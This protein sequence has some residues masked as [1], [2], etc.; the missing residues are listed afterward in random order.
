MGLKDFLRRIRIIRTPTTVTT[1][2]SPT[3]ITGGAETGGII[4]GGATDIVTPSRPTSRTT[5]RGGRTVRET[6]S[7]IGQVLETKVIEEP[8]KPK[9]REIITQE[10]LRTIKLQQQK[11]IVERITKVPTRG[12]VPTTIEIGRR[13][14]KPPS[15]II[16]DFTI[17]VDVGGGMMTDYHI[18]TENGKIISAE[19]SKNVEIMPHSPYF[20]AK[21]L[22]G[23]PLEEI[24]AEKL[25]PPKTIGGVKQYIKEKPS[26]IDV[27]IPKEY[28][29]NPKLYKKDYT[30]TSITK[31]VERVKQREELKPILDVKQTQEFIQPTKEISKIKQQ[32]QLQRQIQR[33]RLAQIQRARQVSKPMKPSKLII[34]FKLK[35]AM[36]RVKAIAKER[37]EVFEVF[38][39]RFGEEVKLGIFPTKPKAEKKLKEKE[40]ELLKK[41]GFRPSK[42]SE[43]L[44]VEKKEKRLRKKTTG[45]D[46]QYFRKTP[47]RGRRKGKSLFGI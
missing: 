37:P 46:I 30:N 43:F 16:D 15:P 21:G 1:E 19:M 24:V 42:I 28:K 36:T 17:A 22:V 34:P 45:R 35:E 7:P 20:I 41:K 32:I 4:T 23:K 13:L 9:V 11:G 40:L 29:L 5:T 10:F 31:V 47:M 38:G 12:I 26:S 44:V 8:T 27:Y 18:H 2:L 25:V 3:T 33:Q 39:K 14:R 6:I